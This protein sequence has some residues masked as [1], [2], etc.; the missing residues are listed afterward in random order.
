MQEFA[1]IRIEKYHDDL[2]QCCNNARSYI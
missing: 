1:S 2:N